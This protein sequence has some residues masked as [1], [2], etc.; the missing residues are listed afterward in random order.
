MTWIHSFS[1]R[2]L[3]LALLLTQLASAQA[4]DLKGI[5]DPT[6]PPARLW[7]KRGADAA[8]EPAMSASAVEAAAAASAAAAAAAS[9]THLSAIRYDVRTSEGLALINDEWVSVGDKVKGMSVMSIAQDAVLLNGPKGARRLT[10]FEDPE[11]R[12]KP[13]RT[14]KRGRKEKK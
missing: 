11:D 1:S 12:G 7:V 8:S 10:L 14:A 6:R 2:F 5:G 13:A 4:Q 9:A 3:L